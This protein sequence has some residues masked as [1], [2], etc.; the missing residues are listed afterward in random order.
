[1]KRLL[2]PLLINGT[3]L[4]SV[5]KFS[6]ET[7]SLTKRTT[8]KELTDNF[9]LQV[10]SAQEIYKES[11]AKCILILRLNLE[12]CIEIDG[13]LGFNDTSVELPDNTDIVTLKDGTHK[14]RCP[15]H[16]CPASTYKIKRHINEVHD[17]LSNTEK[18][19]ALKLAHT[20]ERNKCSKFNKY[21]L[22]V[23][24]N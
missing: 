16:N 9:Y 2:E 17:A 8:V 5:Q 15:M 7:S 3:I 18:E 4:D 23:L 24:Y 1:M 21:Y 19:F 22:N 6:S 13:I 12:T 14:I 10:K 11:V 20:M